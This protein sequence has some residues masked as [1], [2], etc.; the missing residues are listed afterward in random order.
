VEVQRA[1]RLV[2]GD[3]H[4]GHAHALA[5]PAVCETDQSRELAWD[6]D[7][8]VYVDDRRDRVVVQL[9]VRPLDLR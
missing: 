2:L 1:A 5:K 4:I 6:L 8:R 7:R 9:A 3:L